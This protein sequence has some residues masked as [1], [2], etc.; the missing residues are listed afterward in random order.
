MSDLT[1]NTAPKTNFKKAYAHR[2]GVISGY[3][4]KDEDYIGKWLSDILQK[5][6]DSY[7]GGAFQPSV[8]AMKIMLEQ[9][10]R[11]REQVNIMIV[12]GFL[13]HKIYEP[14][15]KYGIETINDMLIAM[16]YIIQRA[17]RFEPNVDHSAF[18][19][20]GLFVYMMATPAG[21][22]V[23][24]VTKFNIHLRII[25]KAWCGYLNSPASLDVVTTAPKGWLSPQSVINNN[26]TQFVTN[27]DMIEDPI[28][29][30]FKSYNDFFHRQIIPICRPLDGRD[31]DTVI[32]SANDGTIYRIAEN[33]R[34]ETDFNLKSQPYS[35]VKML[36]NNFVDDFV[37]G[38][39]LQTFLSGHD[40]HRW[41]APISGKVIKTE[42]VPGYMFSELPSEGFDPSAGT[43]SQ[44]YEANVNTRGLVFIESDNKAIGK[45][46]V[47]PIGITEISS[48]TIDIKEGDYVKK[49]QEI[50]RFSYGGS[51]MC[52]V[53]Q[54]GAVKQFTVVNPDKGVDS[55]NGPFVRVNAQIAIANTSS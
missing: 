30:N 34:R 17:P 5:A 29:W 49:G 52:L 8:E 2:F 12:E 23:F 21:W 45:V 3:L 50:G 27:S 26:L 36:N 48:I 24:R 31:N 1:N 41:R 33:V 6:K 4:P 44:G 42:V 16:N 9:N 54:K 28:H 15:T 53:F 46:C 20:S 43:E 10:Y 25:L 55:N 38:S 11:L 40:Y 18:P 51:S 7:P 37:G 14:Q 22:N 39:V 47:I 32:V 35:L 19:M 13:I